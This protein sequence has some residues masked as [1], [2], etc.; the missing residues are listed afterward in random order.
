MRPWRGA[1]VRALLLESAHFNAGESE[2]PRHLR[3]MAHSMVGSCAGALAVVMLTSVTGAYAANA[4][5]ASITAA[6]ADAGRPDADKQ[7]DSGRKPAES[8]AFAG[9]K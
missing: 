4:V 3:S 8:V 5:P 7:K 2:M 1:P 9:I 6:V